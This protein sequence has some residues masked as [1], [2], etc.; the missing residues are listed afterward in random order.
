MATMQDV[1]RQYL[2]LKGMDVLPDVVEMF[3]CLFAEIELLQ[4][5]INV[6]LTKKENEND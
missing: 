3:A 5:R 1:K 4:A 6:L 2:Y